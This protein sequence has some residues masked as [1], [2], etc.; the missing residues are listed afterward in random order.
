MPQT[1]ILTIL[2]IGVSFFLGALQMNP[3]NRSIPLLIITGWLVISGTL[4]TLVW[5]SQPLTKWIVFL[6]VII[7]FYVAIDLAIES[8][9]SAH[10]EKYIS[11]YER[12]GEHWDNG[13]PNE[14]LCL[15]SVNEDEPVILTR[16]SQSTPARFTPVVRSLYD[17][18]A[19][20]TR[21]W[22]TIHGTGL[23]FDDDQLMEWRPVLNAPIHRLQFVGEV[24]VPIHHG[25][26]KTGPDGIIK[27]HFPKGEYRVEYGIE[28][29][30]RKGCSFEKEG[31]FI[32]RI[33]DAT[34][35]NNPMISS[36]DH[37]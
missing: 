19:V 16:A 6:A 10:I 29:E 4:I 28:G 1:E 13:R 14:S 33:Y 22:L 5:T 37:T 36:I 11:L 23:Q 17:S 25:K 24:L 12:N 9:R 2:A 20:N 32:V 34:Q 15:T 30:S 27:V 8:W 31:H 21:I 3:C 18:L 35:A 7:Y 26:R